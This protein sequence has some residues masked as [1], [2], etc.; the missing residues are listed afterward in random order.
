MVQQF[1]SVNRVLHR[2]IEFLVG[3]MLALALAG[4][5]KPYAIVDIDYVPGETKYTDPVVYVEERW[6]RTVS[7]VTQQAHDLRDVLD[8]LATRPRVAEEKYGHSPT[9]GIATAH[10]N[11]SFIVESEA[12]VLKVSTESS[13]GTMTVDIPPY[14]GVPDATLQIG[15]V[16]KLESIR[17][18]LSFMGFDDFADQPAWAHVSTELKERFL[19]RVQESVVDSLA[20][21]SEV[22]AFYD[23]ISELEGKTISFHG[24]FTLTYADDYSGVLEDH[25]EILIT[26]TEM[27]I[28]QSEGG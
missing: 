28:Q 19:K 15:P 11:Y 17:N 13:A 27:E 12:E 16:V 26:L 20:S 2:A 1:T 14:D 21:G 9:E 5:R 18:S 24:C 23:V 8:A 25:E 22:E 6:D 7:T 4:C 3:L 10:R